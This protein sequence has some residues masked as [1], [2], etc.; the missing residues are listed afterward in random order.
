[1]IDVTAGQNKASATV[2]FAFAGDTEPPELGL[3]DG[4]KTVMVSPRTP[5]DG[6]NSGASARII[7]SPPIR[8][9][10]NNSRD[11]VAVRTII[12]M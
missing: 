4:E 9:G 1:M 12:G 5:D 10:N 11:G 6:F 2:A 3:E 7:G 8:Y